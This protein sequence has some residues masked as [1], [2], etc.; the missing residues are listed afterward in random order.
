MDKILK[1]R[2]LSLF[3]ELKSYDD[4]QVNRLDRW[5][6]LEPESAEFLSIL[7][8][9]K[10]ARDVLEIGTSNG[11]STLWIA[12]ALESTDGFLISLEVDEKRTLLA[13]HYLKSFNLDSRVGCAIIDAGLFLQDESLQY[14]LIFLD[15]ERDFYTSYWP[16]I[17]RILLKRKGS[18]LV[19][20]NAISHASEVSDF[21][22]LIDSDVNFIR[23]ILTVGAG[24][25]LVTER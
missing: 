25:L 23:T 1:E 14:D 11:Y 7:I 17:K 8:R 10:S 16:A 24:L 5:R 18:T 3:I 21:I 15:A 12:D 6:N 4:I 9:S 13:R 19:V 22:Q 20:D 2:L